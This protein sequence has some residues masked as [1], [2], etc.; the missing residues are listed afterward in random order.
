[1]SDAIIGSSSMK[2]TLNIAI[3]AASWSS[4]PAIG[5]HDKLSAFACRLVPYTQ[6]EK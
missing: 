1:M 4:S 2:E 3:A 5:R 6:I